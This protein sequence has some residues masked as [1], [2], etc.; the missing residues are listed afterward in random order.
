MGLARRRAGRAQLSEGK[1]AVQAEPRRSGC[2][3]GGAGV[4]DRRKA[5]S[6]VS[7]GSGEG[8]SV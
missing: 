7:R 3:A 2:G 1:G 8:V 4:S 5:G 6:G